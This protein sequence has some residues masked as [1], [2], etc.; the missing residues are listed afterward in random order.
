ML[1]ITPEHAQTL[2]EEIQEIIDREGWTY[3]AITKIVKVDSFIK[4][5]QG[6]TSGGCSMSFHTPR[7][8]YIS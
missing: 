4:E 1:F 6:L 2:R 8:T 5:S 3:A 7:A